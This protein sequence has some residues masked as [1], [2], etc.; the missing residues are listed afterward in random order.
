MP[1]FVKAL[2]A[3]I[4]RAFSTL[5]A[6]ASLLKGPFSLDLQKSQ[7]QIPHKKNTLLNIHLTRC[8]LR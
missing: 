2:R 6:Y 8:L 1:A 3:P 4:S 7:S 5:K